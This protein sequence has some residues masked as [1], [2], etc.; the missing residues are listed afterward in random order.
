MIIFF[1][2]R[3]VEDAFQQSIKSDRLKSTYKVLAGVVMSSGIAINGSQVICFATGD[4]CISGG[5][6][7]LKG[8]AINDCH[9]VVLARRGLVSFLYD[10]LEKYMTQPED[11]VFEPAGN[12]DGLPL[13]FKIKDGILFHLYMTSPPCGE[14]CLPIDSSKS[15]NGRPVRLLG[16]LQTKV[17]GVDGN[18]F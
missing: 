9:A 13:R 5:H 1:F 2:S 8:E 3:L 10:Q 17:E 18:F 7:S 4:D 16:G 11:S 6:L 12:D 14:A 15:L